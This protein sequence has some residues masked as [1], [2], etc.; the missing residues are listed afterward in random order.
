MLSFDH[1]LKY[2]PQ[3][4]SLL[5]NQQVEVEVKFKPLL[6]YKNNIYFSRFL[7]YFTT[8]FTTFSTDYYY[9]NNIR[10]IVDENNKVIV[11]SKKRVY[12]DRSYQK[13]YNFVTS[14][15]IEEK[16]DVDTSK[17][18]VNFKR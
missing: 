12:D 2:V 7:S 15:S 14:I 13:E 16:V 6:T 10:K 4:N 3:K 9:P 11:E 18:K 8:F 5:P 1:L 17:L